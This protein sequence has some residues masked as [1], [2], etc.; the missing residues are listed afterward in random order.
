MSGVRSAIDELLQI[1]EKQ[2]DIGSIKNLLK[3]MENPELVI[4]LMK[5][6]AKLA[7]NFNL[8]SKY[9]D[10]SNFKNGVI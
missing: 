5:T 1:L 4:Q 7:E 9:N 6:S 3:M 10:K 8:P 2:T